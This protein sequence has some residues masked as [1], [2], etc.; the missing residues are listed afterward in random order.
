[1]QCNAF[2]IY[3]KDNRCSA[4]SILVADHLLRTRCMTQIK[5]KK[6]V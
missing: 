1:V 3:Q 6:K 5:P 2:C 4:S